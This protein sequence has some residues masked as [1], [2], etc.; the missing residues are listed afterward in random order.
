M[1]PVSRWSGTPTPD[2]AGCDA[3]QLEVKTFDENL[4]LSNQ[5]AFTVNVP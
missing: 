1:R 5:I 4:Q 3:K 2:A